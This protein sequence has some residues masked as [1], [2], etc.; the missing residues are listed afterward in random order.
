MT[1][2]AVTPPP[3]DAEQHACAETERQR[4]L[5]AWVDATLEQL[6]VTKRIADAGSFDELRKVTFDVKVVDVELAI[7]DA[8]QPASGRKADHFGG[9]KKDVLK[10]LL[11]R[12]FDER[13]NE[14]EEELKSGRAGA[15]G[16][17][18]S[19]HNW[20]ED[21]KLN[22]NGGVRPLLA[23]LILFLRHHPQWQGVFAFDEFNARVV[24]RKRPPWGDETLDA[25]WTDHHDS[26]VRVWF[27]REDIIATLGDVGRAVQAAARNIAFQ[28]VRDYF[29][30]LVWDGTTRLDAWLVTY[31]HADNTAYAHAVGPRFSFRPSRASISQA[32][33][34]ITR[35]FSKARK[36]GR[37]P[38]HCARSRLRMLGSRIASL[39]STAR[40]PPRRRPAC[41]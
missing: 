18:R 32:A 10:R 13:K 40:M 39:T 8:L 22:D 35:S 14:R 15:G 38:R 29:D 31:F 23:N 27:Q 16:R 26:L 21:L 34:L 12:R 2:L 41:C 36:A 1:L 37:S 20:T 17:Q 24:M 4:K 30:A 6:G 9:M 7:R 19:T 25:V 28:P 11:K 3:P 33:K 5:F